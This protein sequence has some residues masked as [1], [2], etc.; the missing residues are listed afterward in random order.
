MSTTTRKLRTFILASALISAPVVLT[1]CATADTLK[2]G[3]NAITLATTLPE[4]EAAIDEALSAIQ[5]VEFYSAEEAALLKK[6]I[7][8]ASFVIT[9]T[10]H[11]VAN[12][13]QPWL[14][15]NDVELLLRQARS[16]YAGIYAIVAPHYNKFSPEQQHVIRA[17]E[18]N[19][20]ALDKSWSSLTTREGVDVTHL[21]R[22]MLNIVSG[23]VKIA[24]L[25]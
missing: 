23:A 1:A 7:E 8:S 21:I 13:D 22:D 16:T 2:Y 9:R 4:T 10:K 12:K 19:L 5:H 17:A 11:L 14:L 3:I 18:S 24:A 15:G 25:L 20:Q 6:H